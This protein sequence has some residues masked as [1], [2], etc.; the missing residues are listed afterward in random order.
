MAPEITKVE[1]IQFNYTYEDLADFPEGWGFTYKPGTTFQAETSA[2]RIHT[3]VGITGEWIGYNPSVVA[4]SGT[5]GDYLIGENPLDRER[6]WRNLKQR[7][8]PL[9]RT[10][11]GPIDI[12]LWDF[13][14]KYFDA[15]IHEL[16]GTY[17]RKLPAYA[18]TA[19]ADDHGGLDSPDAYADFAEEC[20]DMGYSAFKIHGWLDAAEN[21]DREIETVNTVGERVGDDLD[22]MIDPVC[23]L[24]TF[25]QALKLGRACDEQDFYWYEDPF[26]DGGISQHA[27]R[28]LRQRLDTPLLQTGELQRLEQKTDFLANESTDFVRASSSLDGGITGA[29]KFGRVAEGFGIDIEYHIT[30]PAARH[31]QAATRNTNYYEMGLVHPELDDTFHDWPDVYQGGY[32]DDI[33]AV[34]ENGMVPVPEEPG[35]GVEYDWSYVEENERTSV[36]YE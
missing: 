4:H 3:D 26:A 15:P 8:R 27:H 5:F 13:A 2:T 25:G 36:V 24:D 33:T 16:L 11:M 21:I 34:D 32:S 23:T 9:D 20:R 7:L 28:Q 35:L 10:A 22:L 1:L 19:F 30:G 31:I 6:H 14:G 18:S 17:R 12:A 29:I